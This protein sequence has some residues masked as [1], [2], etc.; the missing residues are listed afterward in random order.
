ML[1]LFDGFYLLSFEL[2]NLFPSYSIGRLLQVRFQYSQHH[3]IIKPYYLENEI[4]NY[5]FVMINFTLL[6][7]LHQFFNNNTIQKQLY[8]KINYHS[9]KLRQRSYLYPSPRDTLNPSLLLLLFALLSQPPLQ[10]CTWKISRGN[11]FENTIDLLSKTKKTYKDSYFLF[12]IIFL[13]I[14]SVSEF[15]IAINNG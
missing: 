7:M 2:I 11:N 9:C 10:S 3:C 6:I 4:S 13:E 15:G 14:F 8:N 5:G 1:V 12:E